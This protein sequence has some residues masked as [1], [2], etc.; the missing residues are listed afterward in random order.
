[1]PDF[2]NFKI[3]RN[4]SVNFNIP[5]YIVTCDMVSPNDGRLIRTFNI[6]F[7]DML[8]GLNNEEL[9][10]VFDDTI[11]T[12]LQKRIERKNWNV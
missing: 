8:R 6:N 11:R 2:K 3:T 1:M 7:P 10:E 9:D 4:G 12:I 5:W